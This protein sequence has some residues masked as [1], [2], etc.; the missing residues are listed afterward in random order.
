MDVLTFFKKVYRR[1]RSM[2]KSWS[3]KL[4]SPIRRYKTFQQLKSG[5]GTQPVKLHLG[6]GHIRIP[7]F[8]NVDILESSAVDL[9]DDISRLNKVPNNSVDLIYACHVLEHFSHTEALAVLKRWHEVLKPGGEM[10]I[11]VPDTDR[12]VNIYK[13]NWQHFQMPG[14][15]PWIG[16]IY[17]GQGDPYDFHKTGFNFCWMKHLLDGIGFTGV[18]EYPHE[19]HFIPGVVDASLAKEPFGEFFSLNVVCKK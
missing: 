1:L 5:I 19:P 3:M 8:L 10:R 9:Q 15:S 11:S 14:N 17:G 13:N 2:A 16:L 18:S 4:I 6:C 7:G 12:I